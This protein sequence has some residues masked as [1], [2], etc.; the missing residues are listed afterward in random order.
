ML[1]SV[2]YIS[3]NKFWFIIGL[4]V[5]LFLSS[6][7]AWRTL[8]FWRMREALPMVLLTSVGYIFS[9]LIISKLTI[10]PRVEYSGIILTVVSFTF[11]LI[12]GILAL[13]RLYYSR[14]FLALA[15]ILNI[16]WFLAGYSYR[17][18]RLK[19]AFVSFDKDCELLKL[20]GIECFT[21]DRLYK[22]L[23]VDGIV[24]PSTEDLPSEWKEYIVSQT[25]KGI[26]IY[27]IPNIYENIFGMI[28]IKYFYGRLIENQAQSTIYRFFKRTFDIL[29]L[30]ISIPII[31][32]I[33]IIIAILIKLDSDGPALFKQKRVG[34]GEKIFEV[35]KF[36]TMYKDSEKDGPKFALKDDPRITR[37]GRILRRLHL[38]EL[39]QFWNVLKGEMSF[40]GPRPEQVDFVEEFKKK[41]PYYSLR[42][43]AK[44]GITGWAQVHYGYAAGLEETYQKLEYDLYYVKN[45]S[46]W[47][48]ILIMIKTIKLLVSSILR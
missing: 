4:F 44:P 33:C 16:I 19:F 46:I 8:E 45:M 27:T 14:S 26:P 11:L 39:P 20:K 3:K 21:L 30:I 18:K 9:Y 13:E 32:P 37:I 31:F 25:L 12:I 23:D 41:I 43:L 2:R 40:V 29:L 17:K 42:H 35:I 5:I 38:D 24:I 7:T 28:P 22:D 48:D 34:Q 47:L 15:Y 6:Y 1:Y 10:F 36:R